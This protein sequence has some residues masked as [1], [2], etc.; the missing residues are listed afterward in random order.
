M[1][2]TTSK[3]AL[4]EAISGVLP[5]VSSRS[6]LPVLSGICISAA[7]GRMALEATDLELAITLQAAAGT[8]DGIGK[9]VVPAKT[10]T[11][12]LK[13]MGGDEVTVEFT[14]AEDRPGV[15]VSSGKKSVS[16][17]GLPVSD[18]P[19]IPSDTKRSGI[20]SFDASELADALKRVVLCASSDE[21]RPV[22]TGVQFNISDEG[23]AELV[24]TDSY[25]L[26]IATVGIELTGEAPESPPIIPARALKLLA[27]QLNGTEGRVSI[28]LDTPNEGNGPRL[29]LFSF[30]TATTWF[31]REIAGEFPN[32]K[33]IVPKE[34]GGSFEFD[35]KELAAATKGASQL[36]SQ[37]SVPVRMALGDSCELR[38]VDAGSAS[39]TEALE[40]ASYSQN[41]VGPMEIAFNPDFLLDAIS[42]IGEEKGRMRA[43]DAV[44]PAIFVG[45]SDRY[46]LMPVRLPS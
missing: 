43:T 28:T 30:G 13:A 24:A 9:A 8:S 39:V 20:G 10:L 12:A 29:A 33:Q 32:W 16:I 5:A 25:R 22:L 31:V 35:S 45:Q 46:V 23:E 17:E 11:K 2:F 37:K 15:E 1:R 34:A 4:T 6:S 7:A 21:A 41:G 44:K 18:W 27:K 26:G 14:E 3:K 42:F 40:G 36:R 19:E 38:M